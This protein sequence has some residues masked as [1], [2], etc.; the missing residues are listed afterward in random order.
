MGHRKH[1]FSAVVT[2]LLKKHLPRDKAN[3][4]SFGAPGSFEN[5]ALDSSLGLMFF[6]CLIALFC[7]VVVAAH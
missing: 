6:S 4:F 2:Y 1:A 7:F 3:A 5:L